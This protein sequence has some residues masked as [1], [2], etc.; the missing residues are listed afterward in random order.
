MEA[1]RPGS[2]DCDLTETHGIALKLLGACGADCQIKRTGGQVYPQIFLVTLSCQ[3]RRAAN[4]Y[5]SRSSSSPSRWHKSKN[6]P[7]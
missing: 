4:S 6:V 5:T 2:M 1:H 7:E 3:L